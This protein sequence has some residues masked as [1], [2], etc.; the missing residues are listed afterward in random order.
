MKPDFRK[1]DFSV[2]RE[3]LRAAAWYQLSVRTIDNV[4]KTLCNKHQE[5]DRTAVS[6]KFRRINGAV[7]PPWKTAE[8]EEDKNR[9]SV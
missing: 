2:V 8:V 7:D 3:L 6:M 1:A 5:V 4:W 9:N